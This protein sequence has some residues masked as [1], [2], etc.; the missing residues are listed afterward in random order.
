MQSAVLLRRGRSVGFSVYMY[1]SG[2][3]PVIF[4]WVPLKVCMTSEDAGPLLKAR[5]AKTWPQE[6]LKKS[7]VVN[8]ILLWVKPC[9]E[10]QLAVFWVCSGCHFLT[11]RLPDSSQ[12]VMRK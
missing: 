8:L 10:F 9:S 2:E 4:F 12:G 6:N 7:S 3:S 5:H 11:T 1:G